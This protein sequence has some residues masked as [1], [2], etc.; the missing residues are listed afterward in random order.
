MTRDYDCAN[1]KAG[2]P[3]GERDEAKKRPLSLG[4]GAQQQEAAHKPSRFAMSA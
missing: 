1:T 3:S 2:A 4:Q